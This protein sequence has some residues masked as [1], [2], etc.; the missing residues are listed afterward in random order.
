MA[1]NV[2]KSAEESTAAGEDV[3]N[4]FCELKVTESI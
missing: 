4:V 1:A 2:G 3:L